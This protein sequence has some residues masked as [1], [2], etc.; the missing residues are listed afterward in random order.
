M[1]F[2]QL[3]KRII[4][5]R[6]QR[7]AVA[8]TE[9]RDAILWDVLNDK[10]CRIKIL[11]SNTLLTARYPENWESAPVWLKPGQAVKVNHTAGNRNTLVLVGF[12]TAIPEPVGGALLPT[13]GAGEDAV[14]SG[15]EIYPYATPGMFIYVT[16]GTYRIG[17]TNYTA[18][19]MDLAS[20]SVLT[21]GSG[22]PLDGTTAALAIAAAHGT[23]PRLDLIVIGTDGVVDVVAG[24]AADPPV[25]PNVPSGHLRIGNVLVPA[26]CTA[27]TGSE[28]NRS[29]TPPEVSSLV[30]TSVSDDSLAWGENTSTIALAVRD[31]YGNSVNG[32]WG[33]LA[34]V[35]I[36]TGYIDD[37]ATSASATKYTTSN[38]GFAGATVS[39]TYTRNLAASPEQSAIITFEMLTTGLQTG[40]LIQL[41]DSGGDLL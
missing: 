36:G 21:L 5:Q 24:T 6:A 31:Q 33:I 16:T 9:T 8:R 11:G 25:E 30:I 13:L 41:Y 38:L 32:H 27:I 14:L 7:E 3:K 12:G 29:Y 20:S 23:L 26:A 35:T 37:N 22:A 4:R 28:V 18:G 2:K 19:V 34:T 17:G 10:Q 15:L 40:Q 1:A 39:F